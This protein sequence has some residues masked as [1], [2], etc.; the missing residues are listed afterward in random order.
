MH[1][2]GSPWQLLRVIRTDSSTID[3]TSLPGG[4]ALGRGEF[5][6]ASAP[7]NSPSA[8]RGNMRNLGT[9]L[10]LG[11]LTLLPGT[12]IAGSFELS[13][14]VSTGTTWYGGD[15]RACCGPRHIGAGQSVF[16]DTAI[17][18]Q[19][20]AFNFRGDFDY[21]ENPEGVGHEVTLVLQVWDETGTL[22]ATTDT[23]VPET[24]AGGWV[25]WNDIDTP[26]EEGT[27]V[28]FTSFLVGAYDLN[29]Y[30]TGILTDFDGGYLEGGRFGSGGTSD[31]EMAMWT[32]WSGPSVSV[33]YMF[34]LTGDGVTPVHGTTWSGIKAVHD[35]TP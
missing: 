18:L 28:V 3:I 24:F 30:N 23:V 12:A 8:E 32:T 6:F 7:V 31:A 25:T 27:T 5:S 13:Y 10:M 35:L 19:T 15:N 26:I 4:F 11:V 20:F 17:Q 2:H 34:R 9:T 16:I 14:E 21:S 22:L 33:D 1:D 29:Q